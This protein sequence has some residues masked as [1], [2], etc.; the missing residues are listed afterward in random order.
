M[1]R[2]SWIIM[3]K[4]SW[5]VC[6]CWIVS[7]LGVRNINFITILVSLQIW[8]L[9]L[10]CKTYSSEVKKLK[11]ELKFLTVYDDVSRNRGVLRESKLFLIMYTYCMAVCCRW[12]GR[13]RHYASSRKVAGSILDVIGFLQLTQSFQPHYGPVV[14]S[15]SKRNEYQGTSWG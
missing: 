10:A 2:F 15:A 11:I 12:V 1:F 9:V 8:I 3:G 4:Y 13:L 6:S 5:N 14:D 7:I